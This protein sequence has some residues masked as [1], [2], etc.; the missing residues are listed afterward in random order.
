MSTAMFSTIC[1]HVVPWGGDEGHEASPCPL[2]GLGKAVLPY[3]RED[4]GVKCLVQRRCS[5]NLLKEMKLVNVLKLFNF[6]DGKDFLQWNHPRSSLGKTG[7]CPVAPVE[8]SWSQ[9][10][11]AL[12]S[13]PQRGSSELRW[14]TCCESAEKKGQINSWAFS[15]LTLARRESWPKKKKGSLKDPAL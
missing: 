11:P 8:G 15:W 2:A 14:E 10:L 12:S 13:G 1:F 4:L 6:K 7:E 3:V 5:T 9:A